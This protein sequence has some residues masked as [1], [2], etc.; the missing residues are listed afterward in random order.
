M[1]CSWGSMTDTRR[2]STGVRGGQGPGTHGTGRLG[3]RRGRL[4]YRY[5]TRVVASNKMLPKMRGQ[6]RGWNSSHRLRNGVAV[7]LTPSSGGSLWV[8]PRFTRHSAKAIRAHAQRQRRLLSKLWP[9]ASTIY[10][11]TDSPSRRTLTGWPRGPKLPAHSPLAVPS[12]STGTSMPARSRPRERTTR[13]RTN[14]HFLRRTKRLDI[15]WAKALSIRRPPNPRHGRP[16]L[17]QR[18]RV[19]S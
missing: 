8:A 1:V 10:R 6:P 16:S 17:T 12:G 5:P 19:P 4:P 15:K 3:N 2:S 18:S 9:P 14:I 11:T 7:P 13:A